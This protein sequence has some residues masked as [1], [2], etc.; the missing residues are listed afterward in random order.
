MKH[1]SLLAN[2][3]DWPT[4]RTPS[5]TLATNPRNMWLQARKLRRKGRK[6]GVKK[7]HNFIQ[8][9]LILE[10]RINGHDIPDPQVRLQDTSACLFRR[11]LKP[12]FRPWRP[13][14]SWRP[15]VMKMPPAL[16]VEKRGEGG[17]AGRSWVQLGEERVKRRQWLSW[18]GWWFGTFFIFPYI[19]NNHPNWLIF[20]RGVAQPPTRWDFL[21]FFWLQPPLPPMRSLHE[22]AAGGGAWKW[23]PFLVGTSIWHIQD[24]SVQFFGNSYNMLHVF[25][26]LEA[27]FGSCC[28]CNYYCRC[29]IL[30]TVPGQKAEKKLGGFADQRWG[31]DSRSFHSNAVWA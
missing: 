30:V 23:W 14:S 31:Q 20:F 2:M 25:L 1:V 5:S 28:D 29:R 3:R 8:E 7:D 13:S 26:F 16:R 18:S 22:G 21:S 27:T 12:C 11:Q 10:T 6:P 9:V 24:H 17:A 19:G 15:S 4:S